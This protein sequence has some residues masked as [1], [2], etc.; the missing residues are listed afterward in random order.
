MAFHLLGIKMKK[1]KKVEL[2][3]GPIS[4]LAMLKEWNQKAETR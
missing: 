4:I 2:G 1:V 3:S